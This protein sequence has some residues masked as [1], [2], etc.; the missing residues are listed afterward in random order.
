M[1]DELY[2]GGNLTVG[3]TLVKS[4]GSFRIDHPLDPVNKYLSHSFVESPDM[5]NVYDGVAT[6]DANAFSDWGWFS[7]LPG[8][9]PCVCTLGVRAHNTYTYCQSFLPA[10]Q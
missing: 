6:L 1:S 9:L 4:A 7:I 8:I 10:S 5:K 2:V 3:G